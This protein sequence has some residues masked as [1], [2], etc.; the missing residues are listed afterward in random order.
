VEAVMPT[1]LE[2]RM[3]Y[4]QNACSL[5]D[6]PWHLGAELTHD[7]MTA[8]AQSLKEFQAG[9]SSEGRH[10]YHQARRYAE[11]TGDGEYM[12]AI[13][14]FIAEEQRHARDLGRFLALNG[15]S[16][17]KTTFTDRVFRRL[18]HMVEDLE[19]SIA[20]LVTA[21]IIAKVYYAALRDATRSL[22]LRRLCDQIFSDEVRHVDFQ[23]DQ[24]RKLRSGRRRA[25][26]V[27]TMA[28]QYFLYFGTV[29]VVWLFHRKALRRG[30]LS[31]LGWWIS[32][33]QEFRR[34]FQAGGEPD[35]A[36]E[37]KGPAA[38][39]F[40]YNRESFSADRSAELGHSPARTRRCCPRSS[41][42][43]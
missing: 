4:E 15:I 3:Y 27:A 42:R 7:D 36:L 37:P 20:V 16:L 21:E 14:L 5:L 1:S 12:A 25:G 19:L 18:R 40:W 22:I 10:L 11:R 29:L 28:L 23:V 30:G 33:W 31:L 9:E 35:R 24:L 43:R 41:I 2:W 34:A 32:C 26:H 8:I 6:I 13:R 39:G 17:V 38:A